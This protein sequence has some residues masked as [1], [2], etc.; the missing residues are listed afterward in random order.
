MHTPS[1]DFTEDKI[2]QREAWDNVAEGWRKWWPTFEQGA[3]VVGGR[4][5]ELAAI[6]PGKQVPDLATG[7][8]EPAVTAARVVGPGGK[9]LVFQEEIC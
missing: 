4:L 1:V 8:G 7:I 9:E 3:Q 5:V 2:K 6:A